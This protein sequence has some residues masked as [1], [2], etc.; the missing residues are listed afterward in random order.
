MT[1]LH[2]GQTDGST[3]EWQTTGNTERLVA[4]QYLAASIWNDC[5]ID[6]VRNAEGVSRSVVFFLDYCRCL[7]GVR[8]IHHHFRRHRFRS[9]EEQF[10]IFKLRSDQSPVRIVVPLRANCHRIRNAC[11]GGPHL[12]ALR[13][14]N[15]E[16]RV[17]L[18]SVTAASLMGITRRFYDIFA[19]N[20][21]SFASS[22]SIDSQVTS[23]SLL[24][25]L[26]TASGDQPRVN[27]T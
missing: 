13:D 12:L 1:K 17:P 11:I 15:C 26:L 19:K 7:Y 25:S 14:L 2:R 6:A 22:A 9:D 18:G 4:V 21:Q 8:A 16:F 3:G 27:R 20:P 23:S 10:D 24:A 5:G